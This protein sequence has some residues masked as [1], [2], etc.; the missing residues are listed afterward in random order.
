MKILV[1]LLI[2]VAA[3]SQ[4]SRNFQK[5]YKPKY[6]VG[7]GAINLDVPNYPGAAKAT[8]RTIPFPWFIY[9]GEVLRADEEGTRARFLR[10][11][12]LE[13]GLSFGFNFAIKSDANEAREG[14]PDTDTLLGIGP[15]LIY[16][17]LKDDPLQRINLGLGFRGNLSTDFSTRIKYQGFIVEPYIRYWRKLSEDSGLTLFT[18][19]SLSV[20]DQEYADFFY[21]IEKQYETQERSA[22]NAKSGLVDIAFS[23]GFSYDISSK[24]SI[25]S[26]VNYSNL[27]MAANKESYLV[28]EEHNI[29]VIVGF[30]WLFYESDQMVK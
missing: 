15:G 10:D 2:S 7:F 4:I 30:A 26:G 3:H 6:E 1:L 8:P 25:F 21:T 19:F 9:R 24:A 12:N 22:Y 20:S 5:E 18:G 14:M 23:V 16:R 27:S 11:E 28:E 29:G 17:F 13:L